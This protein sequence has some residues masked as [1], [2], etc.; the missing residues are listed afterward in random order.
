MLSDAPCVLEASTLSASTLSVFWRLPHSLLFGGFHT[1]CSLNLCVLEA[2]ILSASTHSVWMLPHCSDMGA[3]T[4]HE[5]QS[6]TPSDVH[7]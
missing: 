5:A 1:L 3:L 4:E 2:S 7:L 6:T